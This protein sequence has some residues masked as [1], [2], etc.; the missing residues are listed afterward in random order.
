MA[1]TLIS[2]MLTKDY[3]KRCYASEALN[4]PW[5]KNAKTIQVDPVIMK[6]TLISMAKFNATQKL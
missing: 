4:D 1:K 3:T 6:Q 5:F 2:K